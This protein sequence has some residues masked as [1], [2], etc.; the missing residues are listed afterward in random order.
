MGTTSSTTKSKSAKSAASGA[1]RPP[2]LGSKDAAELARAAKKRAMSQPTLKNVRKVQDIYD[3]KSVL[4]TGGYAVVWS[5]THKATKE[6][7]AIKV[8]KATASATPQEDEVTV[9]EIRNEIDVMKKL[10]HP[11]VI[12]VKEYFVQSGK[13]YIVMSCLKGGELLDALL[14]LGNYTEEDAKCIAK[15]L[16]DALAYMHMNNVTHRDLKLE[17]L[18]L[19]RP[20]DISSVVIADFGLARKTRSARQVFSTQCGTPSYVAPEILLGKPYSPAVDVWSMGVI[21]YTLLIGSFPFAHDDQQSLFRLICSGKV[22]DQQPE[23]AQISE[24]VKDLLKGLLDVDPKKR[25]TAADA[26]NHTWFTNEQDCSSHNLRQSHSRLHGFADQMKLQLR[27]FEV[28][29]H[30]VVQGEIGNEVYLIREGTCDVIVKKPDGESVKVAERGKGDFIGEMAV[31]VRED[32]AAKAK[33]RT[34]S[35]VATSRVTATCLTKSDMQWAVD[36]DYS[37]ENQIDEVIAARTAELSL[38]K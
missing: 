12:Y 17:N 15:Q 10:E 14:D 25:L 22:D 37:L 38:T 13:F 35:V 26:L 5:A 6:E 8:M 1:A 3:M 9:D 20:N 28:G 27:T 30:L 7:F 18:L 33:P 31:S 19:A 11:N 29:Q 4:G 21:L 32:A 2:D 16:L 34:A 36:H 23:W 24:D